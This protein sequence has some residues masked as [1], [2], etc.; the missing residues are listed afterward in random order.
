M[1]CSC[2]SPH[3]T[4]KVLENK[5]HLHSL[6]LGG[7]TLTAHTEFSISFYLALFSNG[8]AE[9]ITKE[10]DCM[11]NGLA[12]NVSK[13]MCNLLL[14]NKTGHKCNLSKTMRTLLLRNQTGHACN[15]SKTIL[16]LFVRNTTGHACSL[17]KTMLTQLLRNKTDHAC[18][19]SKTT[20]NLLLKGKRL[21]MHVTW[22]RQYLTY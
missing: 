16:N 17:S 7:H 10:Q 19:L 6:W 21:V 1:C 14:K 5:K 20:F 18:N 12:G 3:G 15:L 4:S 11:V 8:N 13:I 22:V 9:P 2:V